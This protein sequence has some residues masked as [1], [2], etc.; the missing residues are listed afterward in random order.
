MANNSAQVQETLLGSRVLTPQFMVDLK[1]KDPHTLH[2]LEDKPGVAD[3]CDF[4]VSC[5]C[6]LGIPILCGTCCRAGSCSGCVRSCGCKCPFGGTLL[7]WGVYYKN[8]P[9]VKTM[10]EGGANVEA[11][12]P[13]GEDVVKYAEYIHAP[14][15][16]VSYLKHAME[17]PKR[18]G[19][20]ERDGHRVLEALG[21]KQKKFA[22]F[23][24]HHKRDAASIVNSLRTD[25]ASHFRLDPGYVYL[26][27]ENLLDLHDL[28]AS[29]RDSLVLIV[30]LTKDVFTR[31]WCLAEII[32][33]IE[34]Q[35]PIVSIHIEGQGNSYDFPSTQRFLQSPN[36]A[37]ELDLANPGA[38]QELTNQG[39]D[40]PKMGNAI[41]GMLPYI[42]SKSYNV[43][44]SE[45]V[46]EAQLLD[47][48][49]VITEK[50]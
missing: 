9:V 38:V 50:I 29:V 19:D 12:L 32:T 28:R 31:P 30:V 3:G 14:E 46:R 27:S 6:C 40:V 45:R 24:T 26:D 43:S 2:I 20:M 18:Q 41:G 22:F 48:I 4:C 36:F 37:E 7:Y 1:R 5:F 49:G 15:E 33:A 34:S 44:A 17:A 21:K 35:V 11:K 10:V 13:N 23:L 42:I 25:I 16:I 47:I 39:I 8:L